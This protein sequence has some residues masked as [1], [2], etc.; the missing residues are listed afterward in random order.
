MSTVEIKW[1]MSRGC[2]GKDMSTTGLKHVATEPS[3]L[4]SKREYFT[5]HILSVGKIEWSENSLFSPLST[6]LDIFCV[7]FKFC[8]GNY[9]WRTQ[10]LNTIC[11][12]VK[13]SF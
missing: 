9:L 10:C 13:M 3:R 5:F 2:S 11:L 1:F 8:Y 6:Y 7:A 12:L 4:E